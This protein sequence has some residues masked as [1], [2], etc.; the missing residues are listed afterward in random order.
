M[1]SDD[2]N[3]AHS[4]KAAFTYET[5]PLPSAQWN[6]LWWG[7]D[8][9]SYR[10]GAGCH[11]IITFA[12]DMVETTTNL[13]WICPVGQQ[14]PTTFWNKIPNL[15]DWWLIIEGYSHKS[16]DTCLSATSLVPC[17]NTSAQQGLVSDL[18]STQSV[19][20]SEFVMLGNTHDMASHLYSSVIANLKTS[21][22]RYYFHTFWQPLCCGPAILKPQ[23]F[24]EITGHCAFHCTLWTEA[25]TLMS[26]ETETFLAILYDNATWYIYI[27]IRIHT[28][29]WIYKWLDT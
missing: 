12:N 7:V 18:I 13:L 11:D 23:F 22:P 4:I 6:P 21:F 5:K 20:F 9:W 26:R 2:F 25:A 14:G 24:P 8:L 15:K 28:Y 29:K 17:V 1:F 27:F 10:R 19:V 16:N 3:V